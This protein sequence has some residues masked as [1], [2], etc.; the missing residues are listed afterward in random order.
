[1]DVDVDFE[2]QF[3]SCDLQRNLD[4]PII[5]DASP[6]STASGAVQMMTKAAIITTN[7]IVN[8]LD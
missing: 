1:M 6:A 8:F 5:L 4:E 3:L 7:F 2:A